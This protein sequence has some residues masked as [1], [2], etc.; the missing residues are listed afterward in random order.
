M[1]TLLSLSSNG[2]NQYLACSNKFSNLSF[3]NTKHTELHLIMKSY[4][5]EA[6]TPVLTIATY[7]LDSN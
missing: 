1:I 6:K 2:S 3:Q 4:T 7:K 5:N